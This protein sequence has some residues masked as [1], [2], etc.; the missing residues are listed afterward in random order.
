MSENAFLVLIKRIGFQEYT[1]AQR[2]RATVSTVLN[3]HGF[4]PEVIEKQLAHEER[5]QVRKAYN[6]VDYLEECREMLQWRANQLES[7]E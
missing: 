3:E 5:N 7:Q 1:T 2:L 4:R 6:R